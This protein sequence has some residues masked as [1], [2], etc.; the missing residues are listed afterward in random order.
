LRNVPSP[1]DMFSW[2]PRIPTGPTDASTRDKVVAWAP[3]AMTGMVAVIILAA[4]IVVIL[5]FTA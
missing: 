4:L 5:V 3:L 1:M 2:P